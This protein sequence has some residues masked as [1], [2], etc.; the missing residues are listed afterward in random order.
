M[1][2][3]AF[4]ES[5]IETLNRISMINKID[6]VITS[7]PYNTS[8]RPNATDKYNSRYDEYS[9][10]K[11]DDDYIEF[12]LNLFN[13]LD[14]SL[15]QNGVIL[16]NMSYSSE[17][18][19]LM[20]LVVADI[21]RKTPF[22]LADTIVWKKKSALP[23]NRSKNKLTRIVEF[24]YV[25]VR[26]SEFKTFNSN[27]KIVS[28]VERTGQNN[29]ENVFNFIEAKNNDGANE[30]NKATY[31]SDLVSQLLDMYFSKGNII[32]DPFVGTGTTAKACLSKEIY[33]IGSEISK[34]QYEELL[35]PIM[36]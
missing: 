8:S 14:K 24:I 15:K 2:F 34:R 23:N 26:K 35:K 22:T 27:K 7:P 36:I 4:N 31:S 32:Y 12:T 28:T 25:F 29:Y 18:A 13:L 20:N 21:I 16:Y 3:H 5:C 10:F 30:L 19:W 1:K 17:N 33:C 6:G 11:S 9:D